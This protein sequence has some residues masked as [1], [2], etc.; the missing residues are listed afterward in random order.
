ML[1][2]RYMI[3]IDAVLTLAAFLVGLMLR[4]EFDN[5]GY[6][7]KGVWPLIPLAMAIRPEDCA[8]FWK[9]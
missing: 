5:L 8:C 2:N 1:N 6:F 9:A 3:A 7:L 4:F